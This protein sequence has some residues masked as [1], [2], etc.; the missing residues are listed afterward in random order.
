MTTEY[1]LEIPDAN[2]LAVDLL[3]E[4]SQLSKQRIKKAMQQGAVWY[5]HKNKVTRLRRVKKKLQ[6]GDKIHFYYNEQVLN[7]IPPTPHCIADLGAYSVWFKPAGLLSQGSKWSDH[8]AINRWVESHDTKQRPTFIVHRLDKAAQGLILLAHKKSMAAALAALFQQRKIKKI[9]R[10]KVEGC[11]ADTDQ[12]QAFENKLDDKVAISFFQKKAYDSENN[13][14]LLEVQ[15]ETGRK[16][17]IRRHC[18]EL[19]FP[20]VG[21]RLYGSPDQQADLALLAKEISFQ[22]PLQHKKVFFSVDPSLYHEEF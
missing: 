22:C 10:V 3:A 5:E 20:V 11:F 6:K 12:P 18:A 8:C 9:Y 4:H 2:T 15:I 19:G 21:D 14:S 1:H 17:Q 16:H 13:Q 7:K